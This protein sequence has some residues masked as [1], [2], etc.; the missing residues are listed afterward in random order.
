[1]LIQFGG[2]A[3]LFLAI[4]DFMATLK[5]SPSKPEKKDLVPYGKDTRQIAILVSTASRLVFITDSDWT[6]NTAL[7]WKSAVY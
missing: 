2:T 7:I 4:D 1:M 3:T 5:R 6:A